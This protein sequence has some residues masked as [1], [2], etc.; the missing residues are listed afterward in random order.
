[1]F[2]L[3]SDHFQFKLLLDIIF[4]S[5]SYS[6]INFDSSFYLILSSS[7]QIATC[8]HHLPFKFSQ[9]FRFSS[10]QLS[11]QTYLSFLST[12]NLLGAMPL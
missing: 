5:I 8:Y 2:F 10:F 7:V 1:M 3:S 6:E 11:S 9:L 12:K 4:N